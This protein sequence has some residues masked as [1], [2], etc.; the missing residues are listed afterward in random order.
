M[1]ELYQ[2]V[3]SDVY[4]CVEHIQLTLDFEKFLPDFVDKVVFDVGCGSGRLFPFF[5]ARQC[6][7]YGLDVDRFALAAFRLAYPEATVSTSVQEAWPAPHLI[8]MYF[9]VLNYMSRSDLQTVLADIRKKMT[10]ERLYIYLDFLA[11]ENFHHSAMTRSR[12]I[13]VSGR[14]LVFESELSADHRGGCFTFVERILSLDGRIHDLKES[15]LYPW[16]LLELK[17]A[18]N[19]VGLRLVSTHN[20]LVLGKATRGLIEVEPL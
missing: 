17:A 4:G 6:Q 5:R 3:Y 7:Y 16:S 19:G 9:N 20:W 2:K 1:T 8:L 12:Q 10:G 13:E 15:K 11:F 14:P 18:L